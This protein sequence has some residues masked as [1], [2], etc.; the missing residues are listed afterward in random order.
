M[1]MCLSEIY[2]RRAA[3]DKPVKVCPVERG[4]R[5][6]FFFFFN[7]GVANDV[8]DGIVFLKR[9]N[10]ARQS[11][12]LLRFEGEVVT[13]LELDAD[14]KIIAALHTAPCGSAGMP[15]PQ[16]AGNELHDQAVPPN[17]EMGGN[18]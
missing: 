6:R 8:F 16:P 12:I 14:R 5:T 4:T 9:A 10:E 1:Q 3:G 17:E 7:V 13:P 18:A 15:S 11:R 2:S